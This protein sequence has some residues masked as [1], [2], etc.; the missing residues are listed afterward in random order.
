MLQRHPVHRGNHGAGPHQGILAQVHGRRAGMGFN[1]AQGQIE[2]FLPQGAKHHTDGL[3]LVFEYRPLF[4]MRLEIGAHGMARDCTWAGVADGIEGLADTDSFGVDLGQ[5]FFQGEFFGEHTRAHHAGGK[6]RALFIGPDHHLQRRL[7]FNLQV[8][9][10]AQHFQ[11]RQYPKTAVELAPR[12]LGIDMAAGHDRR[13]LRIAPGAT[14]KDI[15]HPINT[16]AAPG[17]LGP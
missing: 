6:S 12:G 3:A 10:R 11:A 17:L 15:T 13:Q 9:E 1:A 14:G 16:H 5:G 8:I 2:P 4:D 7:G